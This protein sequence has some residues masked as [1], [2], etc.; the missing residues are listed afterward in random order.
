MKPSAPV[1]TNAERHPHV[2]A[3]HGTRIGVTIAPTLDPALKIPV[4]SARSFAGNHS[5]T[6]LIDAGKLPDSPS[7]RANRAALNAV[8]V[9][10]NAADI[11]DRLHSVIDAAKPRRVPTRSM[12]RPATRKPSA[13]ATVN[14]DTT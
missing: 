10:A 13:Y 3:S 2:I 1:T 14:Q 5:A 4:A 7:P 8:V 6:V 9:R 12:M 11:A